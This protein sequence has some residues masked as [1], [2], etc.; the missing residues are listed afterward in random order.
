MTGKRKNSSQDHEI[1]PSVLLLTS[2]GVMFGQHFVSISIPN[3]RLLYVLR[4]DDL[5][6]QNGT[7]YSLI[8]PR[9]VA[10]EYNSH[11][12]QQRDQI[13]KSMSGLGYM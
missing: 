3:T 5:I 13:F 12:L 1:L 6:W 7:I 2:Y 10:I 9:M 11:M 4:N 8:L